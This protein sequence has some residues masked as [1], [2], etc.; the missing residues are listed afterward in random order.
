MFYRDQ[1][2]VHLVKEHKTM[3]MGYLLYCSETFGLTAVITI[4]SLDCWM[5]IVSCAKL[6]LE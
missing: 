3:V 5:R 2:E 4:T 6:D 1:S